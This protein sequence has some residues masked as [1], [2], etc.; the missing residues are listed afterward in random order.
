MEVT[1]ENLDS[2]ADLT[3]SPWFIYIWEA[4][5][6][7]AFDAPVWTI[8]RTD[9]STLESRFWK[10]DTTLNLKW[11]MVNKWTDRAALIY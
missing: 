5:P 11:R 6:G 9:L 2:I 8:T 10:S 7:S 1:Y 4:Q 3:T